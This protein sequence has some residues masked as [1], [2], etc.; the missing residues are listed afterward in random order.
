MT[1]RNRKQKKQTWRY[2]KLHTDFDRTQA[3]VDIRKSATG[4]DLDQS[5]IQNQI[6]PT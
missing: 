6:L 5:Q 1:F 4:F 3:L 2:S